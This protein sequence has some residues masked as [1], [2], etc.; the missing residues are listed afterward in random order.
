MTFQ[1]T[2]FACPDGK[3]VPL[4]NCPVCAAPGNESCGCSD[5]LGSSFVD[6]LGTP[7]RRGGEREAGKYGLHG[8]PS[9]GRRGNA[10]DRCS[11]DCGSA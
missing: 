7:C 10:F 3:E 5:G 1:R 8:V 6:G 11:E 4:E 2:G 9:A